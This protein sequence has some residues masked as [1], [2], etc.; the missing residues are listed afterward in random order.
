V[1]RSS[2]ARPLPPPYSKEELALLNFV[3]QHPKEAAEIAEAQKNEAALTP[4]QPL[5]IAPLKTEPI[6]IAALN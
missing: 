1:R 4:P 3:Q 5:K 2:W 6:T